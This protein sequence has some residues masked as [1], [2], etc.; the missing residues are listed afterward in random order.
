MAAVL[1]A[2]GLTELDA[3]D[4]GDRVPFIG[5]LERAGEER[6]FLDRLRREF[7]VD[8]GRAEEHEP[9]DVGR[10]RRVD[11]VGFDRKIVVNE[12]RRESVI[13]QNPSH[14]RGGEDDGVWAILLQPDLDGDLIAQIDHRAVG[15]DH[16]ITTSL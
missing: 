14:L 13:G 10:M 4:L 8:A 1:L 16:L 9:V 7:G 12:V 2:I 6:L 5:R 15:L 11:D 3:G